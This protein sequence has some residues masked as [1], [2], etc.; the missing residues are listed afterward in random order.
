M[1]VICIDLRACRPKKCLSVSNPKYRKRKYQKTPDIIMT[2]AY[3]NK[4][5][6]KSLQTTRP[7]G[8]IH[9]LLRYQKKL[10]KTGSIQYKRNIRN[11]DRCRPMHAIQLILQTFICCLGTKALSKDEARRIFEGSSTGIKRYPFMVSVHVAGHFVCAGSL[12][13]E[14]LALSAA[15]CLIRPSDLNAHVQIRVASDF[16]SKMGHLINIDEH[17]FHPQF[18]RTTLANNLVLLRTK[19]VSLPYCT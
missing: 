3:K 6:F 7:L 19:K 14:S 5:A 1:F 8:Y 2:S 10:T 11:P 12:V 16:V 13:H 4:S 9:C 17:I 15:S 18:D